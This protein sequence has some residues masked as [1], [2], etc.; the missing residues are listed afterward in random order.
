MLA[1]EHARFKGQD[2]NGQQLE[3]IWAEFF[4]FNSCVV[5][6]K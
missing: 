6:N 3:K 1:G 5:K 2:G 4:K